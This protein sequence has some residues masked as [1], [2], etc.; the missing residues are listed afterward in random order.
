M[1]LN[2]RTQTHHQHT[3]LGISSIHSS[4][5][6]GLLEN[7]MKIIPFTISYKNENLEK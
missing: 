3:K 6:L 1:W 4:V 5:A 2:F 7:V